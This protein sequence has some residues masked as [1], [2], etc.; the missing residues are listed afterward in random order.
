MPWDSSEW[1]FTKIHGFSIFGQ[2]IY[3]IPKMMRPKMMPWS[4]YVYPL[5]CPE[6]IILLENCK[7]KT[8][9]KPQIQ[10][11]G[12]VF[13]RVIP[14]LKDRPVVVG[15]VCMLV[16]GEVCNMH[17]NRCSFNKVPFDSSEST[18]EQLQFTHSEKQTASPFRVRL[19]FPTLIDLLEHSNPGIHETRLEKSKKW[20]TYYWISG[21]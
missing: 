8:F 4:M 7:L 18:E 20:A 11:S 3:P 21:K 15:Q 10:I 12:A 2:N 14:I 6:H 19:I 13:F 5:E 16:A 17:F 1:G 9:V